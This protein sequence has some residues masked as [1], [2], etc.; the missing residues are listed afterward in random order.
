MKI[1]NRGGILALG[2]IAAWALGSGEL[3]AQERTVTL[4]DAIAL[5]LRAQPAIVQAEGDLSVA[6]AGKREA[7]GGYLPSLTFSSGISQNS[8]NRW[9]PQTQQYIIGSRS[10]SYSTGLNA[11]LQIFDGFSRWAQVKAAG[12]TVA[13]ADAALTN[14][15]FQIILQTKQAF[16]NAVAAGELLRVTQTQVQRSEQQLRISKDKLAAGSAI[17]SD[18]LRSTVDLGNARLALLNAQAQLATAQANLARL[19][20]V[21]G[22]VQAT[23]T[24]ALPDIGVLDTLALRQEVLGQSPS[25]QSAEARARAARAQVG[26]SRAQYFPSLTATFSPSWAGAQNDVW[27]S[28]SSLTAWPQLGTSWSLRFSLSWSLF[29]GFSRET[30]MSRSTASRDAA[31]A[32]AAEARR[33]ANANFTQQLASLEAAAQQLTIAQASRAAADEDLRVQQERYRLGAATIVDVLTSQVSLGQAEVAL[34]QA[35]LNVLVAKAQIEA[36]LGREL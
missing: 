1:G 23:G 12:A 8:P 14:Q 21:D 26:V 29:N 5:A 27:I 16:F 28:P 4:E 30:A 22:S 2:L 20:G 19:I 24:P 6:Y 32:S 7:V 11:S 35:R 25:V 31:E 10:V 15:R 13:S 9:N 17:R 34:V 36:L 33:Q 18:T 3:A